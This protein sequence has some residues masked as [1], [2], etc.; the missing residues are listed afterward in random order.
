[1]N[2]FNTGTCRASIA[3][4]EGRDLTEIIADALRKARD[5]R[6]MLAGAVIP[7]MPPARRS[8]ADWLV[9]TLDHGEF[10]DEAMLR[11][12]DAFMSLLQREIDGGTYVGWE[13][14]E[15]HVRGGYERIEFD[16]RAKNLAPALAALIKLRSSIAM[17]LDVARATSITQGMISE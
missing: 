1:M 2:S 9:R 14:D 3:R 11:D 4:G 5:V 13:P 16:A 12:I 17:A 10:F 6:G 7:A 8:F 15:Y